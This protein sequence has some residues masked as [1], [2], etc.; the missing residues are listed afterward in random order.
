M[1][2]PKTLIGNL[3]LFV[4]NFAPNF[5]KGSVIL[6]KSLLER[7]LSPVILI[8]ILEWTKRPSI[9]LPNVPEFPEFN[10]FTCE[11]LKILMIHIGGYPGKYTQQALNLIQEH[12]PNIFICGH[13]HILKI[14]RDPKYKLIHIN[15]GAIGING[16]HQVRTL[17]NLKIKNKLLF[18]L[19]VIEFDR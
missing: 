17:I 15:P 1:F 11:G 12:Q 2:V 6:E 14:I 19:N 8:L 13:S 10:I 16:F 18:D 4:I 7:L 9:S 3:P 5:F